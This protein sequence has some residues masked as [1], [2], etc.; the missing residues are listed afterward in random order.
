G[1]SRLVMG[2]VRGR[3]RDT[4][5]RTAGGRELDRR[6]ERVVALVAYLD[7]AAPREWCGPERMRRTRG[8][9]LRLERAATL[10]PVIERHWIHAPVLVRRIDQPLGVGDGARLAHIGS[11]AR[12]EQHLELCQAVLITGGHRR[13][14]RD[15]L[16][17]E[18]LQR[19]PA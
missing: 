16:T 2:P 11:A 13:E 17:G 14:Q 9:D 7:Q 8:R 18:N 4:L 15:V 3:E 1:G 19:Q 10:D 12:R 5:R 6:G